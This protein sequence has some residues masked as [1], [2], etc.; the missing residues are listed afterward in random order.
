MWHRDECEIL[1]F[2]KNA[3]A[4]NVY[5]EQFTATEEQQK[6][7]IEMNLPDICASVQ[8]RI[9]SIL[10]RKLELAAEQT[11]IRDI[12][13]AGGVSANSGLRDT[14]RKRAL[15]KGWEVYI[16]R[17]EYCTDNAAM[18][19]ITGKFLLE[20]GRFSDQS[21]SATARYLI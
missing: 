17:F 6:A 20:A 9:I 16:P 3:G 13:I 19:S 4:S 1:Y 7:F 18:I 12:C 8:H 5:K 2:L 21:V 10:L 14:F 15:E 11:G